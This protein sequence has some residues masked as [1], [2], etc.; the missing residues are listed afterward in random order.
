MWL[1]L[2]CGVVM[3]PVYAQP[4]RCI[5]VHGDSVWLLLDSWRVRHPRA[6][7]IGCSAAR[8]AG[9][10]VH[11]LTSRLE[12]PRRAAYAWLAR[13][14]VTPHQN[15]AHPSREACGRLALTKRSP[16]ANLPGG[17]RGS[18]VSQFGSSFP[19]TPA[20]THAGVPGVRNTSHSGAIV[21]LL[22]TSTRPSLRVAITLPDGN[23]NQPTSFVSRCDSVVR[24]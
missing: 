16:R 11:I 6:R 12:R 9:I 14:T 21:L 24:V 17:L 8:A 19:R 10:R 7:L 1:L 13:R 23:K 5:A 4:R 3:P 22:T 20:R 2:G 18:A 15:A